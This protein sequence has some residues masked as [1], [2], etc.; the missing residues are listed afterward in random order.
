MSRVPIV[1]LARRAAAQEP[2]LSEAI[3]QVL[4]SGRY[5]LGAE[6]EAFEAE[7]ATFCGRRHATSVAS[8]TDALRLALVAL[9]LEPGDE[10]IV[11]GFTAVPTIAAVCLAG[12]LPVPVDVDAEAATI[13]LDAAKA[14]VTCR[15]R[16][17]IP[18]HLFGRP[19]DIPALDVAVLEDGAQAHGALDPTQNSAACAYSFYPTKNLGG[20]GDGGAIVTDDGDLAE[21]VRS[22]RTHGLTANGGYEHRAIAGNSR[23]S[24][25]EAAALRVGLRRLKSD[26][27]RRRSI[28]ARYRAAAPSLRWQ[29]PHPSHVYHQCVVRMA[30]RDAFRASVTF[31]TAIHYPRAVTQQPAYVRFVREPCPN[32]EA[33]AAECVSL[34]CFPELTDEEVDQVCDT[35]ERVASSRVATIA[36]DVPKGTS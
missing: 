4:R 7:F 27:E 25:I 29:S 35:L 11:P 26:N 23:L 22:L 24:E 2:A 18:V 19:A 10:V 1:D 15:T 33:W 5:L 9:G 28:A 34:P 6:T 21:R 3:G 12:A 20:M 13:D 14:A 17:V 32:A 16:A 8:G 31:E 30:D 36:S